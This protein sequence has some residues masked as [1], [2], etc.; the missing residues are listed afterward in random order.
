MLLIFL[1]L[2]ILDFS[3]F[4]GKSLKS[5]NS[6]RKLLCLLVGSLKNAFS[7]FVLAN[8]YRFNPTLF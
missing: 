2:E 3:G 6:A 8:V 4:K 7:L 1:L 5:I